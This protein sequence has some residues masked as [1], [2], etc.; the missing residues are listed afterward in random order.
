LK[1]TEIRDQLN[2]VDQKIEE[3]NM[4]IIKLKSLPPSYENFVETS[5]ITSGFVD[6]TFEHALE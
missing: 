6:L 2:A 3:E 5:T 1:I 4:A